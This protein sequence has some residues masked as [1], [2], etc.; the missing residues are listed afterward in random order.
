MKNH[1]VSKSWI[2]YKIIFVSRSGIDE[3]IMV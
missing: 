3:K 1:S 2:D